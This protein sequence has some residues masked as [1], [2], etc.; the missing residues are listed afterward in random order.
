MDFENRIKNINDKSFV[1]R[2]INQLKYLLFENIGLPKDNVSIDIRPM[3]HR[4]LKSEGPDRFVDVW[5]VEFFIDVKTEVDPILSEMAF[6]FNR[7]EK[8]LYKVFENVGINQF[9]EFVKN[10]DRGSHS[11]GIF[12]SMIELDGNMIT[13]HINIDYETIPV[14]GAGSL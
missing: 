8:S 1:D 3:L 14:E 6:V 11:V 10:P 5:S 12:V 13:L 7:L 2:R 9:L 4:T